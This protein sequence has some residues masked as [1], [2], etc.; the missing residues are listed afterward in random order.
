MVLLNDQVFRSQQE[1]NFF[2]SLNLPIDGPTNFILTALKGDSSELNWA[3]REA[4]Y[5]LFQVLILLIRYIYLCSPYTKSCYEQIFLPLFLHL[6]TE[7][8]NCLTSA[9]MDFF[10][11]GPCSTDAD[12]GVLIWPWQLFALRK[13]DGSLTVTI[14]LCKKVKQYHYRLGQA[15]RFPGGW[16]SQISRQSAHEG[17]KVVS[18]MQ[19]LLLPPRKYSWYSFLLEAESTPGP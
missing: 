2:S 12:W 14:N 5:P 13:N 1:H 19:R 11:E 10:H 15:M 3:Q 8:Q 18:P 7:N 4:N 16:G 9:I 6:P 17:G